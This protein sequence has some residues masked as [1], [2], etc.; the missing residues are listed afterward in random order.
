MIEVDEWLSQH[1]YPKKVY[2]YLSPFD[3]KGLPEGFVYGRVDRQDIDSLNA[4]IILGFDIIETSLIFNQKDCVPYFKTECSFLIRVA[5]GKDNTAVQEI[6]EHAFIHSRFHQD[7]NIPAALAS[8]IKKNWVANYFLGKRGTS[9]I[10]CETKDAAIAGFMLLINNTIDLIA[11]APAYCRHG[12]ALKMI[13]LVNQKFGLL[14]AGTK[15]INKASI[16]LYQKAGFF[17]KNVQ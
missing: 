5:N 13:G 14:N 3:E 10:V 11:V 15:S 4:L 9:M 12:I 1:F 8:S 6:A 2:R 7:P 16:R 17:L